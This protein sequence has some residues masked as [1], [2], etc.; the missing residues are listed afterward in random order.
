MAVEK[1]SRISSGAHGGARPNSGRKKGSLNKATADIKAI[2]QGYGEQAIRT[3]A[4]LMLTAEADSTKVAAA[5]ELLDRGYG[6]AKQVSEVEGVLGVNVI[7]GMPD[8]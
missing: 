3:L 2:A 5:K 7:T 8:R 1:K 4:D 6:R